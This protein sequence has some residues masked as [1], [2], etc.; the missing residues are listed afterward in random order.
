MKI[1]YFTTA[2]QRDDYKAFY[3]LWN[4]SLNPSNQNFH[5]KMIRALAINNDVHVIS[6]RPFSKRKCLVKYLPEE[7]K[8]EG[9]ISWHYI[10]IKGNRLRRPFNVKKEVAKTLRKMDLTDAIF[11]TDT[12]NPNVVTNANRAKKKYDKPTIGVVTDSPSN[13][14]GTPR[15]YTLYLL[16]QGKGLDGY[17]SLTEGLND[18]FNEENKPS[19]VLEGVVEE[20]ENKPFT[21]KYGKYFFFGGA[22]MEKYGIYRLINAFKKLNNDE[23]HLVICG[24]HADER[25]L[26][27]AIS[28][29]KNIH[30]LRMLPVK[31]VLALEAGAFANVNPRPYSQDLDRFSIPSKTIEYFTS[32]KITI[33]AQS[34]ILE[35]EFKNCAIW[36]GYA[37]EEEIYKALQKVIAMD[38]QK[39][40]EMG[41][42][43]KKKA[44]ELYSLGSVNRKVNDFLGHFFK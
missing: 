20:Q 2:I 36:C 39:R 4:I 26:K 11:I 21:G 8:E 7:Y 35:K 14:S 42:N 24:H 10:K 27:E 18:L 32:G 22:L 25:K 37:K 16:K 6:V 33:S 40:I 31:E 29:N 9:N 17:I 23:Y 43:A 28:K 41:L 3:K 5:N 38:E 15:S 19:I 12:I 1:V 13:I 44:H 30:Y 34:T